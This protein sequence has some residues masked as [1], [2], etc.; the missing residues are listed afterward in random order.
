MLPEISGLTPRIAL[1]TVRRD[2]VERNKEWIAEQVALAARREGFLTTEQP[3]PEEPVEVLPGK[4]LMDAYTRGTSGLQFPEIMQIPTMVFLPPTS[5]M[6]R[7][8]QQLR[9]LVCV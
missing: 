5:N 3:V 4:E 8:L 7:I 2:F 1:D 6:D 9:Q